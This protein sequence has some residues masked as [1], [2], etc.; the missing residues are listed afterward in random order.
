MPRY[1][2]NV[3]GT[4]QTIDELGEELP[5]DKAAWVEATII[6]GELFRDIDGKSQPG[7]EWTLRGHRRAAAVALFYQHQRQKNEVRSLSWPPLSWHP[8]AFAAS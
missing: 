5:D 7:Q 3:Q 6:A 4:R 1:F 8:A 2:F